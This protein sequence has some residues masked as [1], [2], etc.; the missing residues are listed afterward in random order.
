VISRSA[1]GAD[2]RSSVISP[3]RTISFSSLSALEN[4]IEFE[5]LSVDCDVLLNVEAATPAL[6]ATTDL[7]FDL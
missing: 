1:I 4:A 7:V 5:V 3:E 6:S 2:L